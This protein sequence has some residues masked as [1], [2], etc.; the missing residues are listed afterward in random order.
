MTVSQRCYASG[1]S[2]MVV[3][4]DLPFGHLSAD[5]WITYTSDR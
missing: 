4:D 2:N 5:L 1:S 3:R